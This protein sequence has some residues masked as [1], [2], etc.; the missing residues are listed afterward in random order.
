MQESMWKLKKTIR[1]SNAGRTEY[2]AEILK[3][4]ELKVLSTDDPVKQ[5]Q[6]LLDFEYGLPSSCSTNGYM[7]ARI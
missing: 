5:L 2:V 1:A 6:A 7:N 4:L 3:S